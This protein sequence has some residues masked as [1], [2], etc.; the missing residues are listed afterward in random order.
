MS[1]EFP[2]EQYNQGTGVK[3]PKES[4]M[5]KWV[6]KTGL[7]SDETQ[8]S[9]VLLGIAVVFFAITLWMIMGGSEPVP[10]TVS[11]TDKTEIPLEL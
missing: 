7:V 11:T 4:V 6:M 9:Y 8:A 1:V 2:E 3:A 10:K 5:V